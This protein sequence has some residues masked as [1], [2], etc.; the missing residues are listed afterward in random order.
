MYPL[1]LLAGNALVTG[2]IIFKILTVFREIQGLESRVG[3]GGDSPCHKYSDGISGVITFVVQLVQTLMYR[4]Y[5]TLH[6][7]GGLVVRL[8]VRDFTVNC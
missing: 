3:L 6:T 7:L 1:V 5:I 8:Y 2:L 4:F